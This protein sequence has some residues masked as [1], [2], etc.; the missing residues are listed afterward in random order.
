MASSEDLLLE[1]AGSGNLDTLKYLLATTVDINC[2][3]NDGTGATPLTLACRRGREAAALAL[4]EAGASTEERDGNGRL[5]LHHCCEIGLAAVVTKLIALKANLTATREEGDTAL[6]IAASRGHLGVVEQLLAAGVP[7]DITN[8]DGDTALM[9][10]AV[11]NH[12]EALELLLS[13]NASVSAKNDEGYSVLHYATEFRAEAIVKLLI[14]RYDGKIVEEGE[15]PNA[16]PYASLDQGIAET[17]H[18]F[19]ETL[20]SSPDAPIEPLP[21]VIKWAF[22]SPAVQEMVEFHRWSLGGAATSEEDR[23]AKLDSRLAALREQIW[24]RRRHLCLDRA[25]W[26]KRASEET[27]AEKSEAGESV[28][29]QAKT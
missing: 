10:A 4:L 23:T 28:G 17:L 5:P 12:M 22:S 9:G 7:A 14:E 26:R 27:A 16:Y 11:F 1:A 18:A 21:K 20:F 25:L 19:L 29:V 13:Y 8:E 6:F 3:A 2:H 15:P 24:Q